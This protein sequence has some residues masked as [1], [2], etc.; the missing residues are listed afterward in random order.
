MFRHTL[1]TLMIPAAVLLGTHSHPQKIVA[2]AI[3]QS[4][5]ARFRRCL[6]RLTTPRRL[7]NC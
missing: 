3:G 6:I 4:A 1:I 2:I 7:R 5:H